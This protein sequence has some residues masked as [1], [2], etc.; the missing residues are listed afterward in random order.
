M[1]VGFQILKKGTEII[2]AEGYF[3]YVLINAKTGKSEIIPEEII[4]RYSI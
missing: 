2:A 3:V 4:K 1:K